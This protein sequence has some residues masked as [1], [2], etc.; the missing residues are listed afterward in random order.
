[1]AKRRKNGKGP[2]LCGDNL[3]DL[4]F[5]IVVDTICHTVAAI[6]KK[7][8]LT[9]PDITDPQ[10]RRRACYGIYDRERKEVYLSYSKCK[11]PTK[12]SMVPSLIHEVLHAAMPHVFERRILRLEI[13]LETRLTDKQKRYLRRFIPKH[14][15]KTGPHPKL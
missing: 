4:L 12:I 2:P 7:K 6:K 5:K 10:K 3:T 14:Q 8:N 1:M 13:I 15:V 11:H 9:D